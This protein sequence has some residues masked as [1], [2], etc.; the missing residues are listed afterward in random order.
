MILTVILILLQQQIHQ[1]YQQTLSNISTNTGNI[2]I[3][4]IS[5]NFDTITA[6]NT[7]N[8]STNTTKLSGIDNNANNYSLPTASGS[9]LGGIKVGTNLSIDGDGILSAS[10]GVVHRNGQHLDQIFIITVEM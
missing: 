1:I 9:V 5:S 4:D 2:S 8:I 7:S 6:A 10:S 3:N